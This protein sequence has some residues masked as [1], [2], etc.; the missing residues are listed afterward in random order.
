MPRAEPNKHKF[1]DLFIRRLQPQAKPFPVWDTYQLLFGTYQR[2]ARPSHSGAV[3][4][5][6]RLGSALTSSTR[7][8]RWYHIADVAA[9][10]LTTRT[11]ASHVMYQVAQGKDIGG[12]TSVHMAITARTHIRRTQKFPFVDPLASP[13]LAV[14]AEALNRS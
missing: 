9:F 4:R 10:G 8:P 1:N 14:S 13:L 7:A 6:S 3:D 5:G 12:A 11:L 2:T